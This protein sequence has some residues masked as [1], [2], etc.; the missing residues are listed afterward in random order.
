MNVYRFLGTWIGA[1]ALAILG[2]GVAWSADAGAGKANY[3]KLCASCHG[4]D[5]KGNPAM[6]KSFGEKGLN[7]TAKDAQSKSDAEWVTIT[8]EGKG[9]MPAYG[10]KLS[11][12][13]AQDV[14]AYMR[15]FAGK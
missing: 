5:G 6:I 11:K 13:E 9:K 12:Q 1:S 2:A 7:L 10:K 14:V 15:T 3:E 8:M 4:K